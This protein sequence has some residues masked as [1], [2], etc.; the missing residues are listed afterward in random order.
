MRQTRL[1]A[2]TSLTFLFGAILIAMLSVTSW[3]SWR[4]SILSGGGKVIEAPWGVATLFDAYSGFL[5]FFAW[6]FYKETKN[7]VRALWLIAILLL[8]NIA[9]SIYVLIQIRK[10]KEGEPVSRLLLQ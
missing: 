7:W 8:G 1:S 9:M 10:L 3:A 2:K 5:T 4:E 6:V